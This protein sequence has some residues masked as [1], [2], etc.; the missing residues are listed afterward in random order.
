MPRYEPIKAGDPQA[1]T[2]LR[3]RI[4]EK[5]YVIGRLRAERKVLFDPKLTKEQ[6]LERLTKDYGWIEAHTREVLRL[7]PVQ[8]DWESASLI[9]SHTNILRRL[10][11]RVGAIERDKARPTFTVRFAGGWM[12][13]HAE[14]QRVKIYHDEDPPATVVADLKMFGFRKEKSRFYWYRQRCER[15]RWAA[16]KITGAT[17]PEVPFVTNSAGSLVAVA[18]DPAGPK[19]GMSV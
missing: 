18:P 13:D 12:E 16:S 14:H 15:A 9:R 11:E 1:L 8:G 17:W 10:K 3:E 5:L 7:L 19:A 4:D 6:K 2:K